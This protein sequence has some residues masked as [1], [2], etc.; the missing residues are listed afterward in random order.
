MIELWERW[1]WQA[2]TKHGHRGKLPE[3]GNGILWHKIMEILGPVLLLWYDVVAG[4]L[5]NGSAAL[6]ES[7]AVI[8]WTDCHDNI[9]IGPNISHEI[10]TRLYCLLSYDYLGACKVILKDMG[11]INR[12]ETATNKIKERAECNCKVLLVMSTNYLQLCDDVN[13]AVLNSLVT[14]LW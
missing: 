13:S 7:C 9:I 11:K 1:V 8:G 6:I 2:G 5:A 12:H 4:L 14:I 10:C 3:W